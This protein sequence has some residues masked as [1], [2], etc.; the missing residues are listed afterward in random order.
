MG[1]LK[2]KLEDVGMKLFQKWVA[3]ALV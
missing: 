1:V 2:G 3:Q